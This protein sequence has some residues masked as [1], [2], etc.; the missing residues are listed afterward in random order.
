MSPLDVQS[1]T[2]FS[3]PF[4]HSHYSALPSLSL[5]SADAILGVS[6]FADIAPDQ[7]GRFNRAFASLFRIAAGDTWIDPL[8]ILGPDGNI[9]WK[10]ALYTFSFTVL[11]VWVVLQVSVA[12]L[13]NNFVTISMR[14]ENEENQRQVTEKKAS[15]Q[16]QSPIEPL[17]AKLAT[18]YT[19]SASLT[20]KLTSLYQARFLAGAHVAPSR[21]AVQ[22]FFFRTR[23]STH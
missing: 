8:P 3:P 1:H 22:S 18:E 7:F 19:N 5:R 6:L 15:S 20:A 16:F 14:F 4:L 10:P 23:Q 12:V 11:G 21:T 13:I 17:I 9:Q 2:Q